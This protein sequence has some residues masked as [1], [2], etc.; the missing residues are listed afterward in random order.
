MAVFRIEKTR[1]YTVMSNHHLR[2]MSLSL[3]AKGLLSLM[4][5]LPENWDYTMKGLSRICKDGIDSISGGIRELEEHGYLIRERVRG[6]NGQ[7]GSIEYTILEQPKEP[8]PAQEKPIRENPVQANPTLVTPVQ[9]EPA[10]LNLLR[11]DLYYLAYKNLYAN[12]GA[13]TKGVNDDTADGFSKEKVDRIIQSLADGTYTPNPVRREYIQKKQNSTKKR[14]LGIP[15]FTDKLVQEVLR[16]I[17]ESVYEPIF[18]NNSH[19]FRPNRSCHTALKSLKREFSGVSWFIEGDIKGCFDNIDHRVLANVINAKIKDAR[20]I[21]LI[22]KF[23][24]AGYM[25]DWQYHATYSGCPQGGIV[26]PILA[27]I[28][29]NELDKFVE[30]TAKE[31]YKSRDRHHTPEYDKVTWQIKKAQ[32]QLKTAT[33]QEKTALLQKIAQ[34]KA[35]MHKTPCMSKTDKVIKYIRYAD[36]FILGVKGDKADCER[37]KRQLSDFISQTLKMELSEQKTLITHSNQYARFLGYDIRVRRDQKLKPHGNHVSRTLNGSVELCIPF[38]DKIMPFL[39]GK[40]VIRQ[41]RDGTIEPIARKYI[42]RCTDLEIV[43]TYNSELRGICNYY[44]IASNFNKLQYFEYLM[45]YSCLKTLAGKHESTS[46]KIIRKYRDGNGGWGVPYQTKAGIKRRSFARFMDC[47]NTD[48]WTDKIIDFAI[49]HI[50]SRTSFDDRLS[51]RVCELC[52]KTNVP[53]EIHHV[54]K[55]KNLKGKQLWELAMIAK[56]RKT[57]AVCKDCHHKIHHP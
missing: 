31:F 26:S 46:R 28:Y 35:V 55:V 54:N 20:L 49:A 41:L 4:L 14:P 13:G 24:K 42:F 50:G 39:F 22:W 23:L 43:S 9:E 2:D 30:K 3:K 8:T 48:L 15:T 6:A 53:L 57:L 36:D 56:K 44:S 10:Q 17:L 34:L 25:E 5:S 45:E 21:Q 37:I 16:M 51:A 7:L 1:D 18:S 11:P 40:S 27:N 32:K 52:G 12:K 38:A 33:G 19:G 29:L 47:K